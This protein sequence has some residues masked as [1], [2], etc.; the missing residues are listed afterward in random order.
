MA[1]STHASDGA[2]Y[3]TV[4]DGAVRCT[5]DGISHLVH[6]G[7]AIVMPARRP[8]AVDAGETARCSW[9]SSSRGTAH[10]RRTS[11]SCGGE[12]PHKALDMPVRG[13][14]FFCHG[15]RMSDGS[16]RLRCLVTL[17]LQPEDLKPPTTFIDSPE[18]GL[19]LSS[20]NVLA[21][22]IHSSA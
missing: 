5:I 20:L 17:L 3:V 22:M 13:L 7:E 15:L 6:A 11:V 19:S 10:P 9:W 18:S 21:G 2:A 16:L 4:L 14:V 8:H 1:W 12:G